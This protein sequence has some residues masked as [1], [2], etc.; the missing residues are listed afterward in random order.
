MTTGQRKSPSAQA[1]FG[2]TTTSRARFER[3][4]QAITPV[5]HLSGT[6][7]NVHA[8]IFTWEPDVRLMAGLFP[9][10]AA[11]G[12]IGQVVGTEQRGPRR[13]ELGKAQ[14]WFYPA[15]GLV[16]LWEGF[17]N[18]FYRDRPLLEDANVTALWQGM[19]R[20]LAE[21]FQEAQRIAATFRDPLFQTEEYQAFLRRLGYPPVAP[22]AFGKPLERR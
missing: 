14:A 10:P 18:G 22:A 8:Q 19:E 11:D 1:P 13:Q 9:R 7:T 15:D 16:M 6:R 20:W 4:E 3:L 21:R 5:T 12:T 2:I 17:L